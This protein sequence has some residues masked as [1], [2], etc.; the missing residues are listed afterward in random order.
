MRLRILG[1]SPSVPRPGR[2]CSSYLARTGSTSI[3][4]D[5]GTGALAA[6][7]ETCDYA[8]LTAVVITHMHADHF[9]D[10]IPLRYGSTYGPSLRATPLP[11][12]L[13][14]GGE[15]ILR[16]V[17]SAFGRDGKGDFLAAFE[18][19]EYAERASV[20][21]ADVSLS[22]APVRHYIQAFAVRVATASETLTYSGDSAP[23]EALVAL[24]RD[25][26]L[27]LCEASLATDSENEPRGHSSARE[28]AE[29]ASAA[30]VRALALTHYP[31][32][33][34]IDALRDE[35]ASAF[36]GPVTVVDDAMEFAVGPD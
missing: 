23:C 20:D 22:F 2:A 34:P 29:M 1:S 18:I 15:S 6:L 32:E 8:G 31:A 17:C 12:W 9:L 13:P 24:A 26:D 33:C 16:T 30:N 27:F 7:R 36:A 35:A 3:L 25:S 4:L 28:A 21:A 19:R 5:C 10:L 14:P 11:L